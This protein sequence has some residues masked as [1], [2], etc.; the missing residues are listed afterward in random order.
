[1]GLFYSFLLDLQFHHCRLSPPVPNYCSDQ[2]LLFSG[3]TKFETRKGALPIPGQIREGPLIE[4]YR[5]AIAGILPAGLGP[6]SG[7]KLRI[8][9]SPVFKRARVAR[10]S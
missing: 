8:P 10:H 9:V 4:A 7:P 6:H 5:V 3:I 1:M 2:G